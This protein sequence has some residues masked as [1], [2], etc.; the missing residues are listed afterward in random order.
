MRLHPWKY[1]MLFPFV[2]DTDAAGCGS[3][4]DLKPPGATLLADSLS[5]LTGLRILL[6]EYVPLEIRTCCHSD[7][8]RSE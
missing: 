1:S 8:A 3:R 2:F 4:N 6:L 5:C 7:G